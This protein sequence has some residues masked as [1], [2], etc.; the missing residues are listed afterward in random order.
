[1]RE[2]FI[3]SFYKMDNF[4]IK[5]NDKGNIRVIIKISMTIIT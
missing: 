3:K 2:H 5:K 1:M 4:K